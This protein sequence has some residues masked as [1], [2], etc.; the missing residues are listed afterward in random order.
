MLKPLLKLLALVAFFPMLG[1]AIAGGTTPDFE[2]P[3]TFPADNPF[4]IT[5]EFARKHDIT[6][7]PVPET[8]W[9]YH[10][11]GTVK[12]QADD[13]PNLRDPK[14][15]CPD[16]DRTWCKFAV[17]SVSPM[18]SYIAPLIVTFSFSKAIVRMTVLSPA[19]PEYNGGMDLRAQL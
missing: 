4:N 8:F 1:S 11:D 17:W 13:E 16:T 6:L 18:V 14:R 7:I 12:R 19:D 10:E 5:E 2:A 9:P 3:V 15:W